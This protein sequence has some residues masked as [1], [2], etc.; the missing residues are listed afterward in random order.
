MSK[1]LTSIKKFTC[2]NQKQTIKYE[3][4]ISEEHK[5]LKDFFTNRE[6]NELFSKENLQKKYDSFI[7]SSYSRLFNVFESNKKYIYDIFFSLS[8][9]KAPRFTI[10]TLN[11]QN[12]LDIY[13]STKRTEFKQTLI[14]D[15]T[16][17]S[18]ILNNNQEVYLENNLPIL[19]KKGEYNNPRLDNGKL[20]DYRDGLIGW[21]DCWNTSNSEYYSSTLIVPMSISSEKEDLSDSKFYKH[22]FENVQQNRDSRTIWG[23]LCF[24]SEDLNYFTN[25][26]N[27][28]FEEIGYIIAD[29]L[30]LYLMYFHTHISSSKTVKDIENFLFY[31]ES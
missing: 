12:V 1:L 7:I 8:K 9:N 27:D 5:D 28:N 24:D 2:H 14:N 29:I 21:K 31:S 17:F 11:G 23:F 10:K 22:F 16:G 15:N 25:E 19:F 30:S 13:C 26:N 18:N 20:K 6:R 4:I 3:Y